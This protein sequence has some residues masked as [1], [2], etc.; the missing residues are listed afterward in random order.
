[1]MLRMKK[2][3]R[4]CSPIKALNS[5]VLAMWVVIMNK[6]MMWRMKKKMLMTLLIR[7]TSNRRYSKERS[8][9]LIWRNSKLFPTQQDSERF[10]PTDG[11]RI[12]TRTTTLSWSINMDILFNLENRFITITGGG[13]IPISWRSTNP[14]CYWLRYSYGFTLDEN[15]QYNSL[16]FRV[17]LSVNPKD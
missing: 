17:V 7:K 6:M 12:M 15:N 4:R 13:T 8:L 10:T 14:Y 2:A 9:T 16:E 11:G 1:M 5:G 3:R